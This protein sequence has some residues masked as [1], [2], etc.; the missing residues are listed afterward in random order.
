MGEGRGAERDLKAQM[1]KR[2]TWDL[3]KSAG[4]AKH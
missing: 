4:E 2:G 3:E 1:E